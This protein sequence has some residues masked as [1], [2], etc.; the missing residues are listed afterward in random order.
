[1][2]PEVQRGTP[3]GL[4]FLIVPASFVLIIWLIEL[5]IRQLRAPPLPPLT[6]QPCPDRLTVHLCWWVPWLALGIGTMFAAVGIIALDKND[7]IL[8]ASAW[9]I[10]AFAFGWAAL[11]GNPFERRMRLKFDHAGITVAYPPYGFIPWSDIAK[12]TL[13]VRRARY[14]QKHCSMLVTV[15]QS[16]RY[17]RRLPGVVRW[18]TAGGTLA[19]V[20]PLRVPLGA[21]DVPPEEVFHVAQ[22]LRERYGRSNVRAYFG[23]ADEE[24][25]SVMKEIEQRLD[26]IENPDEWLTYL[27]RS[28]RKLMHLHSQVAAEVAQSNQRMRVRLRHLRITTIIV[29]LVV[30]A[31][32]GGLLLEFVKRSH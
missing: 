25:S 28:E 27:N 11:Q 24:L 20:D 7:P 14:N 17:R 16:E 32:V 9:G 30:A 31:A 10:S 1:M 21:L 13:R 15:T 5:R 19:M 3:T 23:K 6:A 22:C 29:V 8:I 18:L 12:V 4:S 26:S 2:I